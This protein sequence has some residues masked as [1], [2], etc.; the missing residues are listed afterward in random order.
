MRRKRQDKTLWQ[1]ILDIIN[2]IFSR[3]R[4]ISEKQEEKT[5]EA[6]NNLKEEYY[7]IESDRENKPKPQN[8]KEISNKLNNRF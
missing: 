1:L 4:R 6:L 7:K 2:Y 8:A 5:S 3:R